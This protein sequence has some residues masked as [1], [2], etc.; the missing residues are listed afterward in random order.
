MNSTRQRPAITQAK[1]H[2]TDA[3]IFRVTPQSIV[4]GDVILEH[5]IR[6]RVAHVEPVERGYT[7]ILCTRQRCYVYKLF[8]IGNWA[9]IAIHRQ[10]QEPTRMIRPND[11]TITV[12]VG[13]ER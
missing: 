4:P 3:A 6:Y 13:G 11:S 9:L 12:V 1:T 8:R 2:S 7:A 10:V 5:G